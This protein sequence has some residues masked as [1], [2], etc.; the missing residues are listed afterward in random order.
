MF[1]LR[2][3]VEERKGNAGNLGKGEGQTQGLEL[4]AERL[5]FTQGDRT[6]GGSG[7]RKVLA[8][9]RNP[10]WG[11]EP[12]SPHSIPHPMGEGAAGFP[13]TPH[14]WHRVTLPP[15]H[16]PTCGQGRC[17]L[18]PFNQH[19]NVPALGSSPA[20]AGTPSFPLELPR[21][22][23]WKDKCDPHT[24]THTHRPPTSR[25]GPSCPLGDLEPVV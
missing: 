5:R 17:Q 3:E 19:R 6:A 1:E 10:G 8:L 11:W 4:R 16:P 25:P 2:L 24:H 9:R 23:L 21:S 7:A 22:G 18:F 13:L 12:A 14:P 15:P 20:W